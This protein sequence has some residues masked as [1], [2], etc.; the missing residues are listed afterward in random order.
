MLSKTLFRNQDWNGKPKPRR[1]PKNNT[2]LFHPFPF[3]FLIE[4]FTNKRNNPN[5]IPTAK[6]I[7][8]KTFASS[9]RMNA[10]ASIT[11]A[12]KNEIPMMLF[13]FF[14]TITLCCMNLPLNNVLNGMFIILF[15]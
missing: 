13:D 3:I 12:I 10:F 6:K 5:P 15:C 1:T 9:L 4:L 14:I 8:I 7:S 11:T 2:L